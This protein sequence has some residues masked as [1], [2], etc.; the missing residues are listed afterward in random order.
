MTSRARQRVDVRETH[1]DAPEAVALREAMENEMRE[2]YAD[3]L[4]AVLAVAAPGAME[5]EA[6]DVAY[7]GVA[8]AGGVPAGHAALRRLGPDL[9]LK[10][11]Y[12]APAHRGT[13]VSTALLAA[14]E[15]AARARGAARLVLQTGDRQP[16][17]VRLYEREGYEHIPIL[18]PYAWLSF[19]I[20]MEKV[21]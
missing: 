19:S 21:L 13:G 3:R 8:Y 1:W 11:M 20:C 16:D 5:I 15:D 17:A 9:E 18:E 2:R 6:E 12:V 4:E 10:R 7:V 14:A